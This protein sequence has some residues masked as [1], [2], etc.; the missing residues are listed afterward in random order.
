MSVV[1]P[2]SYLLNIYQKFMLLI[3]NVPC[4]KDL[5]TKFSLSKSFWKVHSEHKYI[6]IQFQH[7]FIYEVNISSEIDHNWAYTVHVHGTAVL[8]VIIEMSRSLNACTIFWEKKY[9][10]N[11]LNRYLIT[12]YHVSIMYIFQTMATQGHS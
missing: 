5:W 11:S 7:F 6:R 12:Y 1:Y 8:K 9:V 4:D 2:S 10:F 3:T